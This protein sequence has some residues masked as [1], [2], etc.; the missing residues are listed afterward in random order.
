MH[1]LGRFF[2]F[3]Y[4]VL[5]KVVLFSRLNKSQVNL[6]KGCG[7]GLLIMSGFNLIGLAIVLI[8]VRGRFL[9]FLRLQC[10]RLDLPLHIS[11]IVVK[12]P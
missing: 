5:I 3:N 2:M 12:L 8:Y 1:D 4:S 7:N 6:I 9:A 10:Q 11:L